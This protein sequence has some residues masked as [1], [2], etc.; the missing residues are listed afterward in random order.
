L[1]MMTPYSRE[2]FEIITFRPHH[3]PFPT[4]EREDAWLE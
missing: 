1:S 2:N 3:D 4:W